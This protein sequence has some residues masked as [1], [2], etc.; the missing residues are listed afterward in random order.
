MQR[1]RAVLRSSH[2]D[3]RAQLCLFHDRNKE[4]YGSTG[5]GPETNFGSWDDGEKKGVLITQNLLTRV[6][7]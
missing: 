1:L 7:H 4:N 6:S 2:V 5:S 3:D